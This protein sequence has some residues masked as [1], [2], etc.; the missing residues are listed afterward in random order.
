[1]PGLLAPTFIASRA[2]AHHSQTP[3]ARD[4]GT[5]AFVSRTAADHGLP[6]LPRLRQLGGHDRVGDV[7]CSTVGGWPR[8]VREAW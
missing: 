7:P 4:A 8:A 5:P 3:L 2:E 6:F 1:M